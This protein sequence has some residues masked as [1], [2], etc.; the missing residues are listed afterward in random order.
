MNSICR[1]TI[2][3]AAVL[4]VAGARAQSAAGDETV[5]VPWVGEAG[6]RETTADI[7][8]GAEGYQRP[9]K[10]PWKT[11]K[12]RPRGRVN[13]E[14]LLASPDSPSSVGGSGDEPVAAPSQS[15]G[16]SFTG[17]TLFDTQAFPPDSMGAAGP[18]QFIVAVNGR[19]R[20][21][22]KATGTADGVLDVNPDVFFSS[23]MT[24]PVTNNFTSDPRIRYDRLSGRWFLIIIDVPGQVGVLPNRI[25]FAVSDGAVVTPATGWTFF[26]FRHDLP[27]PQSNADTGKFADYPT[28]GIDANALYIGVNIFGTRGQG[29]FSSTTAF[30]VRKSSLLGP[31]PI[32]VTPFR[33]LIEGNPN[34]S[35][36]YTPQGV[37]NYDPA[38]TEGY[39]IGVDARYYGR[40]KLRRV[41]NPGGNPILS[42]NITITVAAT[43]GTINVPH[44]GNTNGTSG[45]LDGLDY[46]LLAAHI[47]NGKL[48]TAANIA[49]DNTGSPSG[50][51]TRM[52]IRW[53]EMTDVATG[54]TPS[55]VQWGTLFQRSGTNTTDQRS[56]WMGSIMVSGQGHALLGFSTAGQSEYANAG[57]A[58]RLV[59]DL[60]GTLRTPVLYTASATSY[61][62]PSNPGGANGRRWGDYSYTCLDPNDDMTMWTIQEW[63]HAQDSYAV[64]VVKVLAPLPARPA[65]CNPASLNRGT[66]N[67]NVTLIGNTDGD[68]GFFDPGSGFSNRIAVAIGGTGVTV[69]NV[70]YN[71]PTNLTVNLSV[72]GNASP[73][74]RTVTVTNPDGQSV[75]STN[76][77]LTID[78]VVV[79]N[80]PPVLPAIADQMVIEGNL[81][82]FTNPATDPDGN[83]LSYSL[84]ASAPAGTGVTNN[85]VFTWTPDESQG[86]G[87]NLISM[88]VADNGTPSLSV[89]QTFSVFV[90]ETNAV[91]VLPAIADRTVFEGQLLTFTNSATDSDI[92]ANTL[93]YILA[94]GAPVGA[95]VTNDGVFTWT[96]NESEGPGTNLI[97]MI[98]TDNGTPS[99]SVTQT[100]SV[101]VL[102]TNAVPVLPAI[103]DRTV[104]EGQLLTFTNS[105]TDSDIP[106]NTLTYI[107]ASGAP[108]GAAVTTNGVF[109]WTPNES[110]GPGTNLISMIVADSVIPSLRA[111]QTFGV[112][113]LETNNYAPRVAAVAD[114][115]IHAGTTLVITNTATD[116][117]LP[118]SPVTYSLEPGAPA[119]ASINAASG[120]FSWTPDDTEAGT[121]NRVTIRATDDGTPPLSDTGT[122]FVTVV[123]RPV[124]VNISFS[125]NAPTLDWS[126][127]AGQSYRLQYAPLL[128]NPVWSDVTGD[129]TAT[130][131]TASKTDPASA[132]TNRFYRVRVL[133]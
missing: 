107:L 132:A 108:V 16:L 77:I 41:S 30:V 110:E 48:W 128:V 60:P 86:P 18:S 58:G 13:F 1:L 111:T 95:A 45:Y 19:I 33:D 44:F 53:Y 113:V 92:P 72:S 76:G 54:Q 29:S 25:L 116:D 87:T 50:T 3:I 2:A 52:G 23:V 89:T 4:A 56:Y 91:P 78:S 80:N 49:V 98:V 131:S 109:T 73:G 123:G 61:N 34:V 42:D 21:F 12:N 28:L 59:G 100:F 129:L 102:E 66:N 43:G 127:I 27:T 93:T 46:R 81:L 126:A 64:Q 121:T 103:A 71:N 8:S 40:L 57:Y 36:P 51:D 74:P 63:C 37:D 79:S 10:L 122:F 105:A 5:S 94:S 6:I 17:A 84:G 115:T 39:F 20:S 120:V 96:P 99:L 31:G 69:N 24:P 90:L 124:I 97:S 101:F 62:P 75:P 55:V 67:V 112:F 26:Q 35:G 15:S 14:N 83:A 88:I 70:T 85:G 82:T 22:D 114:R 118:A 130:G 106:A 68:T 117:D 133:P 7:M 11:P 9:P 32:V 119:A 38:A 65:S 104:F 125:N 47:R